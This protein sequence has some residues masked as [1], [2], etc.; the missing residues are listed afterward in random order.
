MMT[1]TEAVNI[2][3]SYVKNDIT[4]GGF[5]EAIEVLENEYGETEFVQREIPKVERS[6]YDIKVIQTHYITYRVNDFSKS[7]AMFQVSKE[8]KDRDLQKIRDDGPI[9]PLNFKVVKYGIEEKIA[10]ECPHN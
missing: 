9:K 8:L 7:L 2:I 6:D 5:K 3:L 4:R 10:D 1:I